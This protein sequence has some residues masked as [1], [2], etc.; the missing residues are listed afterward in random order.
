[1]TTEKR[2]AQCRASAK[3]LHLKK[4]QSGRVGFHW[5]IKPSWRKTIMEFFKT[6]EEKDKNL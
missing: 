1:M 6:L 5:M 3:R 2:K 4:L